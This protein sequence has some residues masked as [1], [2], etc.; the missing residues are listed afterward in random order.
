MS[1]WI[2]GERKLLRRGREFRFERG[3]EVR[4]QGFRSGRARKEWERVEEI[5]SAQIRFFSYKIINFLEL[6]FSEY[7]Y[8]F[9]LLTEESSEYA[10]Y[11]P[12]P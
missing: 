5:F 6:S 8:S 9:L 7:C 3:G 1:V 12:H 10:A 4:S 11:T 2:S